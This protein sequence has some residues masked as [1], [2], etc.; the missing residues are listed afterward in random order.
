MNS[1][2]F[3]CFVVITSAILVAVTMV[4]M[5]SFGRIL[6][7]RRCN[8]F[9]DPLSISRLSELNHW[10]PEEL[11]GHRWTFCVST[12][13]QFGIIALL[14]KNVPWGWWSYPLVIMPVV[15][16]LTARYIAHFCVNWKLRSYSYPPY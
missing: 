14:V 11:V 1:T 8:K 2:L 4:Q 9:T 15:A 3:V 12:P 16:L 13:L 10:K 6:A 5:L 7:H